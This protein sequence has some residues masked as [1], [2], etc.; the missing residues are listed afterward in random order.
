MFMVVQVATAVLLLGV[1]CVPDI[2]ERLAMEKFLI[3]HLIHHM[4]GSHGAVH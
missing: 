3:A 2:Y 4:I 1:T